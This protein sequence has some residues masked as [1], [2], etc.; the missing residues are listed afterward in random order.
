MNLRAV[1][2]SLLAALFIL[3]FAIVT[4]AYITVVN[5]G[6]ATDD[7]SMSSYGIATNGSAG[8]ST[9]SEP[10]GLE[11]SPVLYVSWFDAARYANFLRNG[12]GSSYPETGSYTLLGD[13]SEII[14]IHTETSAWLLP[15][16]E[17]HEAAY[18][19]GA[20][21]IYSLH[22][23]VQNSITHADTNYDWSVASSID[24]DRYSTF[25]NS[26]RS[27][28]QSKFF[29]WNDAVIDSYI[30]LGVSSAIPE[31]NSVLL[32]ICAGTMVFIRRKR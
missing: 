7:S 20:T 27:F 9:C 12:R 32:S 3:A 31:P 11:N 6:D 29:E 24:F 19:N 17:W 23:S 30:G 21:T 16:D 13:N 26:Y 8:S 22:P 10:A 4:I 1:T 25:P 28:G 5:G 18:Y 14:T 15:E 2:I